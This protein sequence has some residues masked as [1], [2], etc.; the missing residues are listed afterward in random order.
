MFDCKRMPKFRQITQHMRK[1]ASQGSGFACLSYGVMMVLLAVAG[2]SLAVDLNKFGKGVTEPMVRFA[3][4]YWVYGS[5]LGG[6]ATSILSE[7]DGRVRIIRGGTVF[8]GSSAVCM[9][10]LAAM[11]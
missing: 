9:G 2:E 8:L 1:T 6:I 5:G 11:S 3:S 7:G 4:D 10:I